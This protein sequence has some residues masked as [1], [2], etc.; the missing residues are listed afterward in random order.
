VPGV[1]D[2]R[3]GYTGGSVPNP[4]YKRV[5][6]GDTGHAEAVELTYDPGTVDYDRLLDV[7]F[8]IHDPTQVNRQG[9]DVGDQYRSAIFYLNE[10]QRRAAEAKIAELEKSGRF[11]KP[12]ATRVVSASRFFQAEDYHQ[13]Y[14]K[15]KNKR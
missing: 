6:A 2:T 5:C 10:E 12:I 8:E 11:R 7:F 14:Y 4:G 1:L 3:V 15:K 13:D 9:P